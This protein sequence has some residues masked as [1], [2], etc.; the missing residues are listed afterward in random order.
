MIGIDKPCEATVWRMVAVM[1]YSLDAAF[2]HDI[3]L[4]HRSTIRSAINDYAKNRPR[5]V[6]LPRPDQ[7][8][9][10]DELDATIRAYAYGKVL[11]E[12]LEMYGAA[13]HHAGSAWG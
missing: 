5:G 12:P 4:N 11:P 7:Y 3:A 2:T 10:V 6:V 9:G 8:G 13:A 1:S